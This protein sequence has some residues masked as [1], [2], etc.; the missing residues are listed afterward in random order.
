LKRFNTSLV[1][2]ESWT[3]AAPSFSF[4][5]FEST[6]VSKVSFASFAGVKSITTIFFLAILASRVMRLA[7]PRTFANATSGGAGN[8]FRLG[9]RE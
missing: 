6:A 4:P 8:I 1:S 2:P 3:A 9:F 7:R 5:K